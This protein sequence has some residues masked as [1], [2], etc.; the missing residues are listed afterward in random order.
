MVWPAGPTADS[1][2]SPLPVIRQ[3]IFTCSPLGSGNAPPSSRAH[4]SP[5][6]TVPWTS[7]GP[8]APCHG[9]D[10][11]GGL[12]P[13]A[14]NWPPTTRVVGL[15]EGIDPLVDDVEAPDGPVSQAVRT[16][17]R[18][19]PAIILTTPLL[20]WRG[21]ARSVSQS[22]PMCGG[23]NSNAR[24]VSATGYS[25]AALPGQSMQSKSRS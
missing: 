14:P 4:N 15:E 2:R 1:R 10:G 5:P 25:P 23:L 20:Q 12:Q 18:S 6:V 8:S 22:G 19:I 13:G 16:P 3:M 21:S 7:G 9:V 24:L 17:T 11:D